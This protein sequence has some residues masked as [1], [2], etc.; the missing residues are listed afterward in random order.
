MHL[1][2]RG[3]IQAKSSSPPAT[4]QQEQTKIHKRW[5]AAIDYLRRNRLNEVHPGHE[6]NIGIIV[7]GGLFNAL[8][9]AL[10][11][12]NRGDYFGNSHVPLLVLNVTYPL[13]PEEF[14]DFARGK[15]ALLIVEEGQPEF[16]E[17]A[18]NK[19]LRDAGSNTHISGKDVLPMA[20]EYTVS[21]VRQGVAAFLEQ[22]LKPPAHD[23]TVREFVPVRD[24]M[25]SQPL[26]TR[27]SGLCTGCPE[28]PLFASMKLLE[29]ELGPR[30]V[31]ADIGCNSFGS[32]PPF[33]VGASIMGYGLGGASSAG[34][35]CRRRA[36]GH[37][38]HGGRRFLAQTDS[39]AASPMRRSTKPIRSP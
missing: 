22:W 6:N 4:Y 38:D 15:D 30:H 39:P 12:L 23:Q 31:S 25:L 32:L 27:P 35:G 9:R 24:L 17:Q 20:G 11:L 34:A 36:P 16:I 28:R 18:A 3:A 8:S 21:V 37:L 7:Q 5:P 13:V 14:V 10:A 2:T 33:N 26:P 1:P 29:R 19:M